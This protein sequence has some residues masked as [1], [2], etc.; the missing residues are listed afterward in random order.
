M[1][2]DKIIYCLYCPIQR[3]PVY[4]GKTIAGVDRPWAHIKEKSHNKEVNKWVNYLNERG[5]NPIIVILDQADTDEILNEKE[6]FWIQKQLSDGYPLLNLIMVKSSYFELKEPYK[7]DDCMRFIRTFIL[8]K[9]KSVKLTQKELGDKA[10]VG[11]RFI[12]E[13]EQ[14]KKTN[15]NTD[16][17]QK[18]LNLFGGTLYVESKETGMNR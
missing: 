3:V 18:V 4:I 12:R 13:I 17:I 8:L 15:F 14:G 16:S 11:L 9:R 2:L 1:K 7:E 6:K 10:G 5:E